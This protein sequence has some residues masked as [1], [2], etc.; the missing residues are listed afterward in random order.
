MERKGCTW[1]TYQPVKLNNTDVE[2]VAQHVEDNIHI[3]IIR[4]FVLLSTY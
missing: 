2:D 1:Q 4:Y 3:N